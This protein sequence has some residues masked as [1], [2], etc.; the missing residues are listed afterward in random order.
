MVDREQRQKSARKSR[1]A[2]VP[3]WA[4]ILAGLLFVWVAALAIANGDAL[5]PVDLV[6][7]GALLLV[8][9]LGICA[10]SRR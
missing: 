6:L 4:K 3:L 7:V 8:L 2:G 1:R 5:G 9:A 10:P